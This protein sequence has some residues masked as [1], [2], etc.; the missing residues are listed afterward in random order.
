MNTNKPQMIVIVE[1]R[2][3]P[4]KLERAFQRPGF[5]GFLTTDNQGY[6]GGVI[7]DWIEE[8]MKVTLITKKIQFM[9]IYVKIWKDL[10]RISHNM[11]D[12]LLV[13]G[14]FNDIMHE[15]K[16]NRRSSHWLQQM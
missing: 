2:C 13:D 3:E 16:K 11:N 1:T 6:A 9:H 5:N 15:D 14:D 10:K 4:A 7:V 8:V 12:H